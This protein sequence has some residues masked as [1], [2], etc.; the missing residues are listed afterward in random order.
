MPLPTYSPVVSE[1]DPSSEHPPKRGVLQP[2]F[3]G[4]TVVQFLTA[5]ND[6]ILK[7]TLSFALAAGGF[8]GL[9]PVAK[10]GRR[11]V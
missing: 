7:S 5:L 2:G 9:G 1:I 11:M 6:N 4:L 10:R 3:L 8:G